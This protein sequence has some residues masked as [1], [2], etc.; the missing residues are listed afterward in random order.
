MAHAIA[1]RMPART[2]EAEQ[3]PLRRPRFAARRILVVLI[4]LLML[5]VVT[6]LVNY[7]PARAYRDARAR[8]E[9]AAS[10]VSSLEEQKTQLQDQL[11]KLSDS[12]Y[13]EALARE[14]LSY[15][16]PGEEL[17]IVTGLGDGTDEGS[18]TAGSGEDTGGTGAAATGDSSERPG[19]FERILSWFLGIF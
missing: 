13:L 14:Q 19:P 15:I 6:A 4:M 8:L 3:P 9:E 7:G 16:K 17:Y 18:V 11:G 1:P 5:G 12:G 10:A 2:G